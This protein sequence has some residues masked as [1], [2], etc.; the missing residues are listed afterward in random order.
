MKFNLKNDPRRT[1]RYH[2]VNP[3]LVLPDHEWSVWLDGNIRP[4]VKQAEVIEW[5]ENRHYGAM[6]H[7]LNR[8]CIYDEMDACIARKKESPEVIKTV[9]DRY[10][11]EC[12]P[13]NIQVHQTGAMIRR[14]IKAVHRFNDE[15]WEEIRFY[16][17]RDQ[18]SFD[19]LRWKNNFD[20]TNLKPDWYKIAE[21]LYKD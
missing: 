6:M 12:V 18:L 7:S 13:I 16:S 2:K 20:I 1:A 14:N 19:Y 4:M 17:K 3:H 9:F 15:W 8:K 10:K 21:H 5:M 11:S